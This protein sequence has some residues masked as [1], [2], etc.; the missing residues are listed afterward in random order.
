MMNS[1]EANGFERPMLLVN[2]DNAATLQHITKPSEIV[3]EVQLRVLEVS[4]RGGVKACSLAGAIFNNKDNKRDNKTHTAST[5]N[6]SKAFYPHSP[7]PA[8]LAI[9]HIVKPLRSCSLT[10]MSTSHFWSR[11]G[12]RKRNEISAISRR[13]CTMPFMM[14][15]HSLNSL[16]SSCML[17]QSHTHICDPFVVLELRMSTSSISVL[18]MMK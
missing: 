12:T 10:S 15:P 5:S 6:R 7:T 14:A 16:F 2:K 4:G 3:M 8:T 9:S 11:S 1:W 17:L 18:C 13:I